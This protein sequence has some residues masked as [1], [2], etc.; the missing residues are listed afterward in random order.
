MPDYQQGKIYTIRCRTDNTLIYVGSTTQSLAKRW[1]GHK[2]KSRFKGMINRKIYSSINGEWD[3]WYI[4]LHSLYPCNSKEELEMKEGEIIRLIGNL[5]VK[6]EGRTKKE[7][8]ETN[9]ENIIKNNKIYRENNLEEL[10]GKKKIYYENNKNEVKEKS[11]EYYEKNKDKI[12]EKITCECGC[13]ISKK[14]KLKHR[15]TQKHLDLLK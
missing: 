5:N 8:R 11:K 3:N 12:N 1:G 15:K 6:I 2:V 10:L 7:Y 14:S 13:I 4:E 9:K